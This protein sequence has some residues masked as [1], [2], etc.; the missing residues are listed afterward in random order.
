MKYVGFE[1]PN[2]FVVGYGLDYDEK[3]RNLRS[4]GV[5]A[6]HVYAPVESAGGDTLSRPQDSHIGLDT[7]FPPTTRGSL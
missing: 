1:I 5:L 6:S 3:Y 2:Q 7:R 4:V